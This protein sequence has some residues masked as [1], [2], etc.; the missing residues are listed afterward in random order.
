M[1]DIFRGN[2]FLCC[3]SDII[4]RQE[5]ERV[6]LPKGG[7]KGCDVFILQ[8]SSRTESVRLV[9]GK[10][11]FGKAP[12]G[13]HNS[14]Y[15]CRIMGK[16]VDHMHVLPCCGYR[17][18]PGDTLIIFYSIGKRCLLASEMLAHAQRRAQVFKIVIARKRQMIFNA[19]L[20]KLDRC[21]KELFMVCS[22]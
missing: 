6:I 1:Y 5:I 15:L 18:T 11:A 14:R 19:A 3:T 4:D 12:R 8:E 22:P 16:V 7:S 20:K 10:N 9:Y 21:R 17:K 2:I 13:V